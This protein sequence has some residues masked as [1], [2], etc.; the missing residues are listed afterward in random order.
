[1]VVVVYTMIKI[2]TTN[3]SLVTH[4]HTHTHTYTHTHTHITLMDY[5]FLQCPLVTLGMMG[6]GG[7]TKIT[8][9]VF[10]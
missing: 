7:H 10:K 1:M 8:F 5:C 4:T 2:D 9:W 6:D 3:T